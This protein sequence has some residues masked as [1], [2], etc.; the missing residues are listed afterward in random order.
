M[1][2]ELVEPESCGDSILLVDKDLSAELQCVICLGIVV[3]ARSCPDC[4][5][6][7]CSA[8]LSKHEKRKK[9]E[10]QTEGS[11]YVNKC[12]VCKKVSF[13]CV[14]NKVVDRLASKLRAECTET[15]PPLCL[16]SDSADEGGARK[17]VRCGYSGAYSDVL[18]HVKTEC[19]YMRVRCFRKNCA[20]TF[21]RYE[22]SRHESV[23]KYAPAA[24]A[25]RIQDLMEDLYKGRNYSEL[26]YTFLGQFLNTVRLG[27]LMSPQSAYQACADMR[28][29]FTGKTASAVLDVIARVLHSFVV[30][31]SSSQAKRKTP[32]F[33]NSAHSMSMSTLLAHGICGGVYKKF[34]LAIMARTIDEWH[35]T[36]D[37]KADVDL[38]EKTVA[39]PTTCTL[40]EQH[41]FFIQ[42]EQELNAV[43][44][45]A[46]RTLRKRKETD[47]LR[48]LFLREEPQA[49]SGEV[50]VMTKTLFFVRA[51]EAEP[52]KGMWYWHN[53]SRLSYCGN[54]ARFCNVKRRENGVGLL[55][56]IDSGVI[57]FAYN[58]AGD[59]SGLLRIVRDMSPEFAA[60]K[61]D[62]NLTTSKR[63]G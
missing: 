40:V 23:C 54:E 55:E 36:K 41:Q 26:V 47:P 20:T 24:F 13:R 1:E 61:I 22:R 58:R 34:K 38:S 17:R 25:S 53:D 39:V 19:P 63:F 2:C 46:W 14:A 44:A 60:L 5:A 4:S 48:G 49:K 8:C 59:D 45:E 10:A 28:L 33:R 62:G 42:N 52:T 37:R 56:E 18:N 6:L 43:L 27:C 3:D 16:S 51:S 50:V 11:R 31:G 7:F 57:G 32:P 15:G 29:F 30:F 12:M 21:L 35:L 9:E